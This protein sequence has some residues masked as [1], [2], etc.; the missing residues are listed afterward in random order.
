MLLATASGCVAL[1]LACLGFMS[2]DVRLIHDGKIRQIAAQ[3][4]LLGFNSSAALAVKD[5]TA[6]EQLLSALKFHSSIDSAMLF[7]AAGERLAEFHY[8]SD[9]PHLTHAPDLLGCSYDKQGRLQFVHPVVEQ[10]E[11]VGTLYLRSNMS[12]LHAQMQSHRQI[13]VWVALCS[14]AASIALSFVLQQ[15]ISRPILKLAGTADQITRL[16]DYSLRV[17][18]PSGDEIGL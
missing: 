13:A 17:K 5:R 15:I 3:A 2:N 16:G 10:G 12:D 14:L 4:E 9:E 7:D 6:A 11:R 18:S 8:E 1:L